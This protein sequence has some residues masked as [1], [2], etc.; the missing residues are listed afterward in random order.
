MIRQAG[1]RVKVQKLRK[2]GGSVGLWRGENINES[3]LLIFL[4][5][6]PRPFTAAFPFLFI[7]VGLEFGVRL[8]K[9]GEIFF[10]GASTS[11]QSIFSST[12]SFFAILSLELAFGKTSDF[13]L[14]D[15]IL[16]SIELSDKLSLDRLTKLSLESIELASRLSSPSSPLSRLLFLGKGGLKLSDNRSSP[17]LSGL[18]EQKIQN[19]FSWCVW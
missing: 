9:V 2:L 15:S 10:L 19:E 1:N 4:L 8:V 14:A 13:S 12:K 7:L 18:E 5:P 11:S 6:L 16:L 3:S 17:I